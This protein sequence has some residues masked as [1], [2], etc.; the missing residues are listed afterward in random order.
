MRPV[1]AASL[2]L[3]KYFVFNTIGGVKARTQPLL[4]LVFFRTL[5]KW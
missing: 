3:L 4:K 2:L 5:K 1:F